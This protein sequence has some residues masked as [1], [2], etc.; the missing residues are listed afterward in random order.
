MFRSKKLVLVALGAAAL[1]LSGTP[2]D[3]ATGVSAAQVSGSG[4]ISPGL[5]PVPRT[6]QFT[7]TS[8]TIT[9]TAVGV[10]A[11]NSG[12]SGCSASG[13]STIHE[14]T[15]HGKGGG[16]WSC[17]SGAL[18]GCSGV[19]TYVRVGGV[20]TVDLAG[21]AGTCANVAGTLQCEF[22]PVTVAP[23]TTAYSLVCAGEV[24]GL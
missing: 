18:A 9:T 15:A 13:G 2:A 10:G 23:P 7:F 6:Q 1:A 8:V 11:V 3:A 14:T 5:N 21:H 4:T 17:S 24:L 19:L 12:N 22:T 20:V 16:T